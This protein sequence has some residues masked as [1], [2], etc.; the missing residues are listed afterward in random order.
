M[1][2]DGKYMI[3]ILL[4][5][6]MVACRTKTK[7]KYTDTPTTGVIPV[8]VDESFERVM[9]EEI[10]VFESVYTMAGI[11]PEYGSE[12]ETINLLLKDSVRLAITT[13]KLTEAERAAFENRKFFPKEL[14][15]ATDGMAL[16]VNKQNPDSLISMTELRQIMNGEITEWKALDPKTKYGKIQ[17]VFDHPNSSSVRFAIDSL[18]QGKKL[19]ADLK[20]EKSNAGVIDFVAQT[21]DAL[22]IVGVSWIQNPD[23]STRLSFI[24]KVKVMGVSRSHPAT[25]DNSFKPWQAYLALN[26]YPLIRDVYVVLTDPRMG[27]ASGFTS[28][29][30]S[31]RGQRIILK[32]GILPATQP[33][34]IVDVK[35]TW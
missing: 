35:D 25:P 11:V 16:I 31:D 20:A 18:C 28:F 14:K 4:L 19:S 33:V 23:D 9:E 3:A 5:V 1:F 2:K 32:A 27:L 10:A 12:V 29:L 24:D 26:E 21:P 8:A 6:L 30:T 34:R 15:I 22:G 13:R 17:V 7:D